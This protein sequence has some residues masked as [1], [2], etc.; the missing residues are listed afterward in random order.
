MS[1][2]LKSGKN[3]S[4]RVEEELTRDFWNLTIKWSRNC[5]TCFLED[6]ASGKPSKETMLFNRMRKSTRYNVGYFFIWKNN[7]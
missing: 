7:L 6:E 5:S 1:L 2:S 3:I 4:T